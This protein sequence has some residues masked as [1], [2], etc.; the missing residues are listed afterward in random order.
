[1]R[2]RAKQIIV[3]QA[4]TPLWAWLRHVKQE[5]TFNERVPRIVRVP[6][7][8]TVVAASRA[9]RYRLLPSFH[10]TAELDKPLGAP[11][12]A[13]LSATLGPN[14]LSAP[15]IMIPNETNKKTFTYVWRHQR[16]IMMHFAHISE[17]TGLVAVWWELAESSRA[18]QALVLQDVAKRFAREHQLVDPPISHHILLLFVEL[19]LA[20][21][22]EETLIYRRS[23]F[24][25]AVLV[26]SEA[27]LS[28]TA[29]RAW[30]LILNGG[31]NLSMCDT[32]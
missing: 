13:L 16:E 7:Y 9:K 29:T 10:T 12:P 15:T 24:L 30:E 19:D 18:D 1:M 28:R 21:D 17:E 22:T 25:L 20:Q 26:S 31:G 4:Y 32:A 23:I 3:I 27:L 2:D 8:P 11:P 5:G 14:T 6:G